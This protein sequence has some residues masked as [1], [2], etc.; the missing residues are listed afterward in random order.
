ML[1][2]SPT[3]WVKHLS[4]PNGWW[5]D[6]AQKLLILKGDTSIAPALKRLFKTSNKTHA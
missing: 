1:N 6:T 4:H 5:R 2:E 3:Q